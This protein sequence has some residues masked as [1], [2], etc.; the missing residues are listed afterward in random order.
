[1]YNVVLYVDV[2]VSCVIV[3]G[4]CDDM[5]LC[6]TVCGDGLVCNGIWCDMY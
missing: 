1:M 5:T 3:Y 2:V 6:M 4:Y